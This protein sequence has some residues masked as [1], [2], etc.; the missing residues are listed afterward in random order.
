MVRQLKPSRVWFGNFIGFGLGLMWF[1]MGSGW[2]IARAKA[3][4]LEV[5][6]YKLQV[7]LALSSVW[8]ASNTLQSVSATSPIALKEKQKIHAATIKSD[9]ILEKIEKD[10]EE[11][12]K[13]LNLLELE[14]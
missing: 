6:E 3:Y 9:R 4:Q 7:G 13:K 2:S 5:A 10:I 12:T 14:E 1:L 11:E 8:E